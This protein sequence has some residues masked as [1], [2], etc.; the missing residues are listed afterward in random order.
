M[1]VR[2]RDGVQS[3]TGTDRDRRRRAASLQSF[4]A[5]RHTYRSVFGLRSGPP[6]PRF[7]AD[8]T[9]GTL[10]TSQAFQGTA[11]YIATDDLRIAVN[12]SIT[13]ERPLLIKGEPG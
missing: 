13:L 6:A 7:A 9:S 1:C 11:R 12:A 8:C 5:R 3:R 10:M 2:R 4:W